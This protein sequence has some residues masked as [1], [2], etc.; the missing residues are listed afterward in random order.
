LH[1]TDY[2]PDHAV[3]WEWVIDH[4]EPGEF[5]RIT[6]DLWENHWSTI[7]PTCENLA[8][9][10]DEL[11]EIGHVDIVTARPGYVD[12]MV[13]WLDEQGIGG[14]GSVM[15]SNCQCKSMY[16]YDYYV[17]DKPGLSDA[18][19][20]NQIQILPKYPYNRDYWND[21]RV[22]VVDEFGEVPLTVSLIEYSRSL[23]R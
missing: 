18:L 23:F 20:D 9:Q 12:E 2:T 13:A 10:I 11:C 14:Y 16:G 7:P 6:E 3:S 8:Q 4:L 19:I 5:V 1:G 15:S 22:Q 21:G 17:D